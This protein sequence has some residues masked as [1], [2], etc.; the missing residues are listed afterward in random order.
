MDE[1][2]PNTNKQVLFAWQCSIYLL[3]AAVLADRRLGISICL[4]SSI[5]LHMKTFHVNKKLLAS[6]KPNL[7]SYC[8]HVIPGALMTMFVPS[9]HLPPNFPSGCVASILVLCFVLSIYLST[10][11]PAPGR[12]A[13][14]SD[15]ARLEMD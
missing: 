3:H 1:N 11:R 14:C 5:F 13:D 10:P 15:I 12:F 2:G 4:L 8:A 9:L 6:W 7:R